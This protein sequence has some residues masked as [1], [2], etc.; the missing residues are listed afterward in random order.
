MDYVKGTGVSGFELVVLAILLLVGAVVAW[1]LY[2]R[3][4]GRA[5]S[6]VNG[7]HFTRRPHTPPE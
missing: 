2:Q 4:S 5:V 6:D 3:M 1:Q 7:L